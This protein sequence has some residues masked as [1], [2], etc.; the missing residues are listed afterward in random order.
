MTQKSSKA[1]NQLFYTCG[2][3]KSYIVQLKDKLN[4]N[5]ALK[6]PLEFMDKFD[7][8]EVI[9]KKVKKGPRVGSYTYTE[10]V[11]K[12]KIDDICEKARSAIL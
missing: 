9:K 1:P 3:D 11:K 8:R 10:K 5:T 2:V 6:K 7:K 12:Q 4:Y